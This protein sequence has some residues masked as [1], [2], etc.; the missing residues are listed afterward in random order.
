M[1]TATETPQVLEY[2]AKDDAGNPI[3][4]PTRIVYHNQEEL[5]EKMQQA[6]TES[7]RALARQ[8]KAFDELRK[9]KLTRKPVEPSI[10][11]LTDVEKKQAVAGIANPTTAEDSVR[12]LSGIESLEERLTKAELKTKRAEYEAAGWKWMQKHPEYYRCKANS[13]ALDKFLR[14][15]DLEY[16]V[17]N[18]DIAFDSIGDQLA[19]DPNKTVVNNDPA[20]NNDVPNNE[21]PNAPSSDLERRPPSFGIAPGTGTGARPTGRPVGMTKKDVIAKKKSD[22]KWWKEVL[23]NP[24][25][26]A[27]VNAALQRG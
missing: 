25:K 21:P 10:K 12:K 26:L 9:A 6:H 8:N 18:L 4:R 24:T 17:G 13:D 23:N 2:Q 27:E 22:P 5:I 1:T 16:T 15:N 3:G 11:K 14:E 19:T 20:A 7:V